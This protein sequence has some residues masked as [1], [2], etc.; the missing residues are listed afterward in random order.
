MYGWIDALRDLAEKTI[1]DE[2]MNEAEQRFTINPPASKE[3]YC[4]RQI[5]NQHFASDSAQRS[6][7][8]GLSTACSTAKTIEW[9]EAFKASADPS[10][11]AIAGVHAAAYK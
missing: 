5:F 9:D 6:V 4:Y 11:R 3:A 2:P 10:G 8:G 7:P 1:S